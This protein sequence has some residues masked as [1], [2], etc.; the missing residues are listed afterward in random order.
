VTE[1]FIERHFELGEAAKVVAR[2]FRPLR[3]DLDFCCTYEVTWPDRTRRFQ[4]YGIDEVQ[5]LTIALMMVHAELL[6]SPE[7]K[8]GELRWLGSRDLGLPSVLPPSDPSAQS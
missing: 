2:F 7:A 4:A 8:R 5:A 6:C 3:G 1:T